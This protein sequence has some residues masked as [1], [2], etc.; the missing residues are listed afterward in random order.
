MSKKWKKKLKK[1]KVQ[2]M[3]EVINKP[4]VRE[5]EPTQIK[6]DENNLVQ[7][8]L[9]KRQM[10]KAR[11]SNSTELETGVIGLEE[12]SQLVRNDVKKITLITSIVAIL[13]V[14]SLFLDKKYGWVMDV[15]DWVFNRFSL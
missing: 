10:A 1:Q 6:I 9:G 15:S 2:M 14:G 7:K 5:V 12:E 3:R 4:L 13:L 11:H 8:E